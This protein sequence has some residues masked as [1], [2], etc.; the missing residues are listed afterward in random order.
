MDINSH[1]YLLINNTAHTNALYSTVKCDGV[2]HAMYYLSV[3]I[4]ANGYP[5]S[6]I[7][8]NKWYSNHHRTLQYW[9]VRW[10]WLYHLLKGVC[11]NGYPLA[12]I[13][14]NKW[15]M[16]PIIALSSTNNCDVV[17][18][19]KLHDVHL[20]QKSPTVKCLLIEFVISNLNQIYFCILEIF[21]TKSVFLFICLLAVWIHKGYFVVKK[22]VWNVRI[23][24][25]WYTKKIIPFSNQPFI[26]HNFFCYISWKYV[27]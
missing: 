2:Y 7:S 12:H 22:L 24:A 1:I 26:C 3:S 18:S 25:F 6:H 14:S 4:C 8:T 17:P 9:K 16:G 21:K 11:E 19:S 5:F 27:H 15:Y 10:C 13:P 23:K 20:P